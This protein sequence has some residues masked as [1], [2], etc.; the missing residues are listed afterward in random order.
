[1][2]AHISCACGHT[3]RT[4]TLGCDMCVETG[5]ACRLGGGGWAGRETSPLAPTTTEPYSQRVSQHPRCGCKRKVARW[6]HDSPSPATR[7]SSLCQFATMD[8][9]AF[10]PAPPASARGLPRTLHSPKEPS[11]PPIGTRRTHRP[12]H[13]Q[14]PRPPPIPTHLTRF[15]Q[16]HSPPRVRRL[17]STYPEQVQR[18]PL[19]LPAA[20][21][22]RRASSR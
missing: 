17:L 3:G 9:L 16:R 14:W 5:S 2:Y 13:R 6:V 11:Q 10:T 19:A 18:P 8:S 12:M 4:W 21:S 15:Q 22:P 20:A 7:P 1:M